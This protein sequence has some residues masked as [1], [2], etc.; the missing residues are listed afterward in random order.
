[1]PPK[2]NPKSVPARPDDPAR[3][4]ISRVKRIALH[5][6]DAA[7]AHDEPWDAAASL[8]H[9]TTPSRTSRPAPFA[10]SLKA[11]CDVLRAHGGDDASDGGRRTRGW[12][13][14]RPR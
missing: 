3:R 8:K 7:A 11:H 1:M 13:V 6:R 10:M 14:R 5:L 4:G 2:E 9:S 12:R